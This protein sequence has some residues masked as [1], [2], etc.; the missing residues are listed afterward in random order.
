MMSRVPRGSRDDQ[1]WQLEDSRIRI[2]FAGKCPSVKDVKEDI[3][4]SN[5][6]LADSGPADL[7]KRGQTRQ[8]DAHANAD[9]AAAKGRVVP[10]ADT[11][12]KELNALIAACTLYRKRHNGTA[13]AIRYF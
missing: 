10:V 11:H 2:V 3:R 5:L 4:R 12:R 7:A 13:H 6:G 9:A 8:D 1:A